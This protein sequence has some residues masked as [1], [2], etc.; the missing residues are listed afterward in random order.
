M[1]RGRAVARVGAGTG[2]LLLGQA[3]EDGPGPLALGALGAGVYA[4]RVKHGH[5]G[6]GLTSCCRWCGVQQEGPAIGLDGKGGGGLSGFGIVVDEGQPGRAGGKVQGVVLAVPAHLA[7]QGGT[8]LQLE[9]VPA[10]ALQV[11]GGA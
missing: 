2:A 3:L 7:F 11:K 9:R 8:G 5:G 4:G 6:L 1:N 10:W